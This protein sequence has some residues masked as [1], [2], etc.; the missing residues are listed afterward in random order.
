MPRGET[1]PAPVIAMF[2]LKGEGTREDRMRFVVRRV[3]L[4]TQ[5]FIL[6]HGAAYG[7][8]FAARTANVW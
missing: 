7:L 3:E 1:I 2:L 8:R 4:L 5:V 6:P